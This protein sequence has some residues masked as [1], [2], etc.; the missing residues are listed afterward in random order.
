MSN[1]PR[2]TASVSRELLSPCYCKPQA[3]RVST[4]HAQWVLAGK[5]W[6][7]RDHALSLSSQHYQNK[8]QAW[9]EENCKWGHSRHQRN[10]YAKQKKSK[11][12]RKQDLHWQ[13]SLKSNNTW[14]HDISISKRKNCYLFLGWI[15]Y[16]IFV[17]NFFES[18][19]WLGSLCGSGA[20]GWGVV[21]VASS[22]ATQHLIWL[23]SVSL[24][25]N[26]WLATFLMN[27]RNECRALTMTWQ[28][29]A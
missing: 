4:A 17:K 28:W 20:A 29:R 22:H 19:L 1:T 25:T 3:G 6:P 27:V 2:L 16:L 9:G 13:S 12:E 18:E 15:K 14:Y 24:T 23:C 11:T 21:A 5:S 10:F 26:H 7:R 8:Q